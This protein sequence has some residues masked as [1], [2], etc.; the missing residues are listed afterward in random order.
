MKR[1]G[2][3]L[4]LVSVFL[5]SVATVASAVSF[6]PLPAP[7]EK[8]V[9]KAERAP[10]MAVAVYATSWE[11]N[12]GGT[13]IGTVDGT[14]ATIEASVGKDYAVGVAM[15]SIEGGGDPLW[16]VH[17]TRRL[18]NGLGV[19]VGALTSGGFTDWQVAAMRSFRPKGPKQVWAADLGVGAYFP[20]GG[21]AGGQ[22][23]V[24]AS[25]DVA[26]NITANLSVWSISISD[27][28]LTRTAFGA[29]YRF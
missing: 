13:T 27:V 22:A 21:D 23:F 20:D 25:Y 6:Y 15:N 4:A 26:K 24:A 9:P 12:V 11:V 5:L 2:I 10:S 16:D 18:A 3:T 14:L 17:A 28:T 1:L 19:Q 29:G 8:G 7:Q